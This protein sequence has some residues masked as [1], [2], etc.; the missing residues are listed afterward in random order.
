M[1][2][3]RW[4]IPVLIVAALWSGR[5]LPAEV[6]G[7]GKPL[8]EPR[9]VTAVT[10]ASFEGA[11][12]VMI[13]VGEPPSLTLAADENILPVITTKTSGGR[14]TVSAKRSYTTNNRV[15]VALSLP[16]LKEIAA[17]GSNQ[18]DA[19]G[20]DRGDLSV[21]LSGSNEVTLAGAVG[22]LT[23]RLAGSS[24]LAARELA[25]DAVEVTVAGAGNAS[26]DA[27]KQLQAKILG[28]GSLTVYGNP[29]VR[30]S[31]VMGSGDIKFVQ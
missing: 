29:A 13:I 2:P 18:I 1:R 22:T 3:F 17:S 23:L 5:A 10:A 26:V 8:V 20:F 11:F 25:A 14:L 31:Q 24:K 28:A 7:D 30:Q 27:R 21:S 15:R 9:P 4:T 19:K 6:V 16:A 12:E